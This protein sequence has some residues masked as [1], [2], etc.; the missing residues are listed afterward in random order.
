MSNPPPIVM[1]LGA[2]RDMENPP[3]LALPM[4]T[5]SSG[6]VDCNLLVL[7]V[8]DHMIEL[9]GPLPETMLDMMTT[10]FAMIQWDFYH[11]KNEQSAAHAASVSSHKE[12]RA[13]ISSRLTE[14]MPLAREEYEHW[15][16][17]CM[18]ILHKM[19]QE[20]KS[21][22][23]AFEQKL[24]HGNGNGNGNGD[25]DPAEDDY[26]DSPYVA[27]ASCF[28]TA[29]AL[30]RGA[31]RRKPGHTADDIA[32]WLLDLNVSVARTILSCERQHGSMP[33]KITDAI[34]ALF[35]EVQWVWMSPESCLGAR[36]GGGAALPCVPRGY[37][38]SVS[39]TEL[40]AW[41]EESA[42]QL[43]GHFRNKVSSLNGDD[44]DAAVVAA[45]AA[46]AEEKDEAAQKEGRDGNDP[47]SERPLFA[48]MNDARDKATK[49]SQEMASL[50]YGDDDLSDI[51]EAKGE[52]A[53]GKVT[54][55]PPPAAVAAAAAGGDDE[56]RQRQPRKVASQGTMQRHSEA[57][58]LLYG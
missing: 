32:S 50:L 14:Y 43:H 28:T 44:S 12:Y 3:E 8:L 57:E 20:K 42:S 35:G 47:P 4:T 54:P 11:S 19:F 55:H 24:K 2:A 37:A 7:I 25:G 52:E 16:G 9:Y 39:T 5:L 48:E 15:C 33:P 34:Q 13:A 6:V 41:C 29:G 46:A 38:P 18:D 53:D 21:A 17:K 45:A 26:A 31:M 27:L 51:P 1:V 23:I 56:A 40:L 30:I 10:M 22:M 49:E 58:D 36:A